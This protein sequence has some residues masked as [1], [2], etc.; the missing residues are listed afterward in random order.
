MNS[1]QYE[2][3]QL[4][5]LRQVLEAADIKEYQSVILSADRTEYEVVLL[6]GTTK[7]IPSG[8]DYFED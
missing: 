3:Q 6:N 5:H 4:E 1:R 8:L 7:T 2:K